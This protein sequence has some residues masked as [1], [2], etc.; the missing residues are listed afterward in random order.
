M[1]LHHCKFPYANPYRCSAILR[2]QCAIHLKTRHLKH[3]AENILCVYRS[4]LHKILLSFHQTLISQFSK[5]RST[6]AFDTLKDIVRYILF[7]FV[8]DLELLF[9][10][11]SKKTVPCVLAI[12]T[13]IRPIFFNGFYQPSVHNLILLIIGTFIP[14]DLFLFHAGLYRL[15]NNLL[16]L[17]MLFRSGIVKMYILTTSIFE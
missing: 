1:I 11:R 17:Q 3:S 5:H 4:F 14:H 2:N 8:A 7:L 10:N 16:I 15:I 9:L 13:A 12:P 6:L